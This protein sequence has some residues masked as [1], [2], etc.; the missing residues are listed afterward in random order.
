LTNK[1]VITIAIIAFIA[2]IGSMSIG[3]LDRN[4][5]ARS[6]DDD[7]ENNDGSDKKFQ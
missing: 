7:Q 4:A 3:N 2:A 1:I 6:S 5:F